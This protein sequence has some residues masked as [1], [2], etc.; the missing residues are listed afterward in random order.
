[1][2]TPHNFEANRV[3]S[4][5]LAT[6]SMM[7]AVIFT[8]LNE[9]MGTAQTAA[10]SPQSYASRWRSLM[11]GETEIIRVD[12][13]RVYVETVL[14]QALHDRGAFA[15]ADLKRQEQGY[16]GTLRDQR[17]WNYTTALDNTATV[18]AGTLKSPSAPPVQTP[19]R[20]NVCTVELDIEISLLTP[21]R[22][23][24]RVKDYPAK[25][26]FDARRCKANKEPVWIAF[27]WIP[28]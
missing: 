20:Y 1:V 5:R 7:V 11:S 2:Q 6:L 26:K 9:Q 13:D 27:T 4:T 23:E 16:R 24:G 8:G 18:I 28:E 14:S 15:L 21:G 17:P 3:L 19:V 10:E 22:I 12:G 25:T